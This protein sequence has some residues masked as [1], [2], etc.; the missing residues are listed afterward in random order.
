MQTFRVPWAVG[1]VPGCSWPWLGSVRVSFLPWQ[2]REHH[3][4]FFF[5]PSRALQD[6]GALTT[7]EEFLLTVTWE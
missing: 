3:A 6:L 5:F 7:W 1:L 4:L 2:L